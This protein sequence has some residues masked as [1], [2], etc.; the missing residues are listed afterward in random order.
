LVCTNQNACYIKVGLCGSK[1]STMCQV[2]LWFFANGKS[3]SC[4]ANQS[5]FQ[6]YD[7]KCHGLHGN[8]SSHV[9]CSKQA[10]YSTNLDMAWTIWL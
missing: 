7:E 9:P 1:H 8:G 6:E 10:Y 2:C 5:S 4:G 3:K